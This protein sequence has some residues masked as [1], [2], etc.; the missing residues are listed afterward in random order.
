MNKNAGN[1]A[2][3]EFL[4]SLPVPAC[5]VNKEGAVVYANSLIKNV[6][7][8]DDIVDGNFFALTGSK[9]EDLEEARDTGTEVK[10]KAQRAD[11]CVKHNSRGA[12]R[13]HN[14]RF[15]QQCN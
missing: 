8:Y 5:M 1:I 14:N 9:L 6:F 13:R 3:A 12:R 15:L 10:I 4:E 11:F 2:G 7:A